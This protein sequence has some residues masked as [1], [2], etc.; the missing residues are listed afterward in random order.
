MANYSFV[1][2]WRVS[3][4]IDAVFEVIGESLRWPEWWHG[5][6]RVEEIAPG[7]ADGIGNVRRYTFRGRLPY[8][9]TFDVRTTHIDQPRA[10]DGVASGELSGDGRW[11]FSL[12][13]DT[14]VVRY[15][16]DVTT[17]QWWMNLL[18][19]IA[20]PVFKWN[21]D[22]VMREWGEGVRRRLEV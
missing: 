10:L 9:L 12:E 6:P 2:V 22:Y 16:W 18:A 4:P 19:P 17:T 5:V 15:E 3:A 13:G 7:D 14:T 11:R 20:R 21:H 1:T 8:D